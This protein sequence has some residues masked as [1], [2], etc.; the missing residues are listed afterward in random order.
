MDDPTGE[1]IYDECGISNADVPHV[2]NGILQQYP[3]AEIR[4]TPDPS[5]RVENCC[6]KAWA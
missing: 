4:V 2:V 5:N 1:I 6:V 3:H